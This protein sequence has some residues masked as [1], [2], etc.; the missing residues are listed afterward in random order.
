MP[1]H[2]SIYDTDTNYSKAEKIFF[3]GLLDNTCSVF[4]SGLLP[5]TVR[6]MNALLRALRRCN[7]SGQ[8]YAMITTFAGFT[9]L[10]PKKVSE[11]PDVDLAALKPVTRSP[12]GDCLWDL[13][14]LAETIERK[15]FD[16]GIRT[17]FYFAVIT[18]GLDQRY[19]PERGIVRASR[20]PIPEIAAKAAQHARAGDIVAAVAINQP[21]LEQVLREIGVEVIIPCGTEDHAIRRAF[22]VLTR[23][24]TDSI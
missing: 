10:T 16:A 7:K 6:E 2:D 24:V 14:N 13:F 20:H 18:D 15:D 22:E 23:S 5:K 12:I 4:T 19:D 8:L 9:T 1:S 17:R 21:G 11:F 3:L